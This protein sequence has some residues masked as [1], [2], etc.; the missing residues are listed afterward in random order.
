MKRVLKFILF[1]II[2]LVLT[3]IGFYKYYEHK[4]YRNLKSEDLKWFINQIKNSKSLPEDFHI[5]YEKQHPKSI[6]FD[7]TSSIINNTECQSQRIARRIYPIVKKQ[8]N[9]RTENLTFEY[10][11]TLEIEKNT[12]QKQCLSWSVQNFDFLYRNK[13][14]ENASNFYFKKDLQKLNANELETLIKILDN[15]T[16]N[17]PLRKK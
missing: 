1:T 12:N 8:N 9:N 17:N 10:F 3:F 16:K 7:L 14:I 4:F 5:V 11:L 2:F 15:P 6:E 13:G